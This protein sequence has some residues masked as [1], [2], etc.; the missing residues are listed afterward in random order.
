MIGTIVVCMF[1][2]VYSAKMNID[3][4]KATPRTAD[5]NTADLNSGINKLNA[6]AD[7]MGMEAVPTQQTTDQSKPGG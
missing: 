4:I 5:I 6:I 1:M 7:R 2:L 3:A